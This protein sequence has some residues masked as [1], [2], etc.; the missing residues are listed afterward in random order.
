MEIKKRID[1]DPV[2]WSKFDQNLKRAVES[3]QGDPTIEWPVAITLVP[4]TGTATV[5]QGTP[6]RAGRIRMA[7]ERQAAFE[8]EVAGL[9]DILELQ[10]A[11]EIQ[12]FWINRSVS[13]RAKL[14]ALEAAGKR[15]EVNQIV[16][17]V[18]QKVIATS[19][20]E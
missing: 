18:R 8:A 1:V 9:V 13:A 5:I 10:G 20:T 3:V 4:T 2:A 15:E 19:G 7:E 12:T 11:R 14:P 16:L 6:D 17:T